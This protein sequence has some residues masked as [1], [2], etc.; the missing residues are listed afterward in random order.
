M[1]A[2]KRH[3]YKEKSLIIMNHNHSFG[4][5]SILK[6][7]QQKMLVDPNHIYYKSDICYHHFIMLP[8]QKT[9]A[10]KNQY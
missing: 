10:S 2:F 8:G 7:T 3:F 5:V 9:T 1:H 6:V 4:V